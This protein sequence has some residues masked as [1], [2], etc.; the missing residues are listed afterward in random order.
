MVLEEV[1][2]RVVN[3]DSSSQDNSKPFFF[4]RT[5]KQNQNK[6]LVKQVSIKGFGVYINRKPQGSKEAVES[7]SAPT[8]PSDFVISPQTLQARLV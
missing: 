7:L 3:P 2:L 5:I 6:D 4:D 8:D 1:S